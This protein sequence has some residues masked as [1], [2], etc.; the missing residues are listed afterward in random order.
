MRCESCGN[1][2]AD[3]H[4]VKLKEGTLVTAHLCYKCATRERKE[5]LVSGERMTFPLFILHIKG[6]P[7]ESK[8]PECGMSPQ[9][10]EQ[11]AQA[12]P[13]CWS[14][15]TPHVEA[16]LKRLWELEEKRTDFPF[17]GQR[18]GK[19]RQLLQLK[20]KLSRAIGREDY[21]EAAHLRDEIRRL[22]R[23]G[24]GEQE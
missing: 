15:W 16:L 19:T 13:K 7:N 22:K 17:Q 6:V 21:E 9:D 20:L 10:I 2:R 1:R 12:C 14:A 8:C 5:F 11:G 18:G 23:E 3:I 4:I 24:S